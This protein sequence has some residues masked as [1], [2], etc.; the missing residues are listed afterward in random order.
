M[1]ELV[2]FEVRFVPGGTGRA[3]LDH[4]SMGDMV[5]R[6]MPPDRRHGPMVGIVHFGDARPTPG[7]L[8]DVMAIGEDVRAG[9]YGEFSLVVSSSDEATRDVIGD[10]AKSQDV[11][12]FV[13]TSAS[14]LHNAE[15]VGGLTE[16]DKITLDLVLRLGGTVTATEL[17]RDLSVEQTTAGNR[18]VSL[19]KKGY[20]QRVVRPHPVG[21]LFIDPR[22]VRLGAEAP[23]TKDR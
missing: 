23:V 19:H 10:I 2:R 18:L 9:R 21:D 17:A 4:P 6:F 13:T 1:S 14:D 11:A 5:H 8:R 20:L 15:P 12:I 16:K 7:A 3:V 22:S